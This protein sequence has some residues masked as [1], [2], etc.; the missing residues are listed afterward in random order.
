MNQWFSLVSTHSPCSIRPDSKV[1]VGQDRP[2]GH[3]DGAFRCDPRRC[4][5]P[6]CEALR[7]GYGGEQTLPAATVNRDGHRHRR[8]LRPTQAVEQ[9]SKCVEDP[10]HGTLHFRRITKNSR[11]FAGRF[12]LVQ[13]A[14]LATSPPKRLLLHRNEEEYEAAKQEHVHKSRGHELC[15]LSKTSTAGRIP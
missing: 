3:H 12:S 6:R 13:A 11:R 15:N 8:R 7:R 5:A 14:G 1:K 9:I 4:G 2:R 10:L